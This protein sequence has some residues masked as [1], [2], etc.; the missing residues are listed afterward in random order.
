MT[1]EQL[2]AGGWPDSEAGGAAVTP[3]ALR[4]HVTRANQ[5]IEILGLRIRSIRGVGYFIEAD[6]A[7]PATR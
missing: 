3:N 7:E 1:H 2:H 4:V 6:A 5:R